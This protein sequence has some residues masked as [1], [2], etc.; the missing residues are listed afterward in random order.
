MSIADDAGSAAD[1]TVADSAADAD[2]LTA[3]S[4]LRIT[5]TATNWLP[6]GVNL[7]A[8]RRGRSFPANHVRRPGRHRG[9][10]LLCL[11]ATEASRRCD[12]VR[13]QHTEAGV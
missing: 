3:A 13:L 9:L 2:P 11:G 8:L 12:R 7:R 5:S 1:S 10:L 4:A 6:A